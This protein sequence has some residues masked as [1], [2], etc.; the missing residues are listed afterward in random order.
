MTDSTKRAVR[1][2]VQ[3]LFGL[4]VALPVLLSVA[5]ASLHI[6]ALG[7]AGATALT[8]S[9]VVAKAWNRAEEA[10]V[11]PAWL[12]AAHDEGEAEAER[13]NALIDPETQGD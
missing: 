7:A 2:G 12:K 3:V 1:T 10:G 13:I 6:A 11:V 4:L 5:G 9:T 8:V